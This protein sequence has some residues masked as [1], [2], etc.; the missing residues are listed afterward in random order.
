[1]LVSFWARL[2]T[3]RDAPNPNGLMWQR[4]FF[5]FSCEV[6]TL[7]KGSIKNILTFK[8]KK[9]HNVRTK[10]N[11]FNYFSLMTN[12]VMIFLFSS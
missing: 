3:N 1:M 8:K 7:L 5:I 4:G 6:F 11:H 12:S 2:C 9:G 10:E